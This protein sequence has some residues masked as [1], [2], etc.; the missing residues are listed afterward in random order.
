MP[1][2]RE[3]VTGV[4]LA[5]GLGTRMG[6]VDKGLQNFRG[7]PMVLQVILRLSPQVGALMINANRNF[8]PY[9]GF[10]LP[11]WPDEVSGFAGPLAGIATGLAHCETEYLMTAPCD[12][13]FLPVDLVERLGERLEAEGAEIAVAVTGAGESRQPHPVF[14]LMRSTLLPHLNRYMDQGGRK[15]GTWYKSLRHVEV[16]FPD[17]EAFRNINTVEEL[18]RYEEEQ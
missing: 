16:E 10:G 11:V 15:I 7:A 14:A 17:E 1:I 3:Q 18:R 13:P 5:G 12:S 8:G 6:S 2:A 9:E 4:I